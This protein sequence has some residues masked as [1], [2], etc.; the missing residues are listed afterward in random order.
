MSEDFFVEHE[1]KRRQLRERLSESPIR[2]VSGIVSALGAA[3][4]NHMNDE[5][6]TLN[7]SFV[8]WKIEGGPMRPEE[9]DVQYK[10]SE[11]T[12]KSYL[13]LFS[14]GDIIC[15]QARLLDEPS[16]KTREALM[17]EFLGE[18]L[19]TVDEFKSRI[20]VESLTLDCE[21]SFE[22]SSTDG[23]LY[24]RHTIHV[25]GTIENGPEDSGIPG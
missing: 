17:E 11:G 24:W 22:F 14:S 23:D 15:I 6:S 20:G 9:L 18:A 12:E 2:K 7:F 5:G 25:S 21:G 10:I 19:I 4:V 1:R 3:T 13:D 16:A 8:G